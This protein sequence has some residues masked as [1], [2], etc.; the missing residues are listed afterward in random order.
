LLALDCSRTRGADLLGGAKLRD[1]SVID[2][3]DLPKP[4]ARCDDG[5]FC[6]GAELCA[7]AGSACLPA[8]APRCDD[9]DECTVDACDERVE[10]C[11]HLRTPRDDDGDGFD[12]CDEDCD[13]QESEI[14]PGA[15]EQCD[16]LDQDC[17]TRADEGT[18]SECGD[19]RPGCRLLHIPELDQL[20][21]PS[22]ERSD[23][24]TTEEAGRRLVL[25]SEMTRRFDA[26]IANFV[27]G[28]VTKIDTR[29][30]VQLARYDSVLRDGSNGAE[31][32]DD[33]CNPELLGTR[34][35][36]NCP[37]RT[38]VDLS[39]AVYV[40]N[41]AFERQG[42]VTK[43]AGFPEDCIDRDG[44]GAISTSQD[45][46]GNGQIDPFV[47]GEFLGQDDECLLWTVDVGG[48]GGVPRALAIAP[49]GR[50]WVGLH[51]E[52]RVLELDPADGR[53]LR[54][55]AVPGIK[56]YGAAI[57]ASGRLWITAAATGTIV[58]IDT[59]S[60][61]VGRAHTAPAAASGCPSSYGL[62]V[63]GD[64][65]VWLAG[66]TCPFAFGYDPD[67]DEWLSVA[68]P[69]SGVTRGIAADD[70]GNVFVASSNDFITLDPTSTFGFV[71][72]SAPITRLTVFRGADGSGLRIFGTDDDPLPGHG[73]IGVGVDSERRAWLINQESGSATRVDIESGEIK[74]FA[75][76]DMPYTYSDFTGFAL[77]RISAPTGFVRE[78][79]EGCEN[80]PSEWERVTIDADLQGGRIELRA[81]TADTP[82][83]LA[84]ARFVGPFSGDDSIDL[85]AAP[86]P[87]DE[88]RFLELEAR[89]VSG[90]GHSSPSLRELV[91]QLHCPL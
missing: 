30:G 70:R 74:H 89:E 63:D 23:S 1:G 5:V 68:L 85:Q 33:E 65:R 45:L 61:N 90:D 82:E 75:V 62:A 34:S 12:A 71:E 66:F 43:I 37:S 25:T 69:D 13:D 58:G 21:A 41:R 72:A 84:A 77:R 91:V 56:P 24:V 48:K 83:G 16:Q 50:I 26:W 9:D 11:T 28:K 18:L 64:G 88:Q 27:D 29:D 53:V 80:G 35:G 55:I 10:E 52:S 6:N 19:C 73:A 14:H 42:T 4:C 31:P 39:G 76:G 57:D 38:A 36:G 32:P 46:D 81:R 3:D 40:G 86:G 49:N 8:E 59:E 78:L 15:T 79:R 7:Q 67:A 87:L 54:S 22:P 60:G 47:P 44:D 17:D 2:D 20:W 51:G